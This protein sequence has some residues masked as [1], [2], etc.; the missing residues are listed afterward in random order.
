MGLQ[1]G[2]LHTLF[3][4]TELFGTR[5]GKLH[6]VGRRSPH[7]FRENVRCICGPYV[8]Q[9]LSQVAFCLGRLDAVRTS[10]FVL[11]QTVREGKSMKRREDIFTGK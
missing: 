3:V 6:Q 5:V 11:S 7:C 1:E 9:L 8:L 2:R 10:F 4:W